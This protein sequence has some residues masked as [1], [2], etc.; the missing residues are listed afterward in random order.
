MHFFFTIRHYKQF[1]YFCLYLS[2][3]PKRNIILSLRWLLRLIVSLILTLFW[4]SSCILVNIYL[5]VHVP[6]KNLFCYVFTFYTSFKYTCAQ[7][8]SLRKC[9]CINTL[10]TLQSQLRNIDFQYYASWKNKGE[11]KKEFR[12]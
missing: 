12:N 5:S 4:M 6:S 11:L 8:H 2:N 7:V 10:L 9:L 1:Q 3:H